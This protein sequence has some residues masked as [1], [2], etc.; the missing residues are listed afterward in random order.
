MIDL[1]VIDLA[2]LLLAPEL[3]ARLLLAEA[4]K[5]G[6]SLLCYA[7]L[8]RDNMKYALKRRGFLQSFDSLIYSEMLPELTS[9]ELRLLGDLSKTLWLRTP[10]EVDYSR[11]LHLRPKRRRLLPKALRMKAHVDSSPRLEQANPSDPLA[12]E[13]DEKD[14]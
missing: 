9:G 11:L 1:V 5:D 7:D 12:P 2:A 3:R 10:E 6:L 8:P 13:P 4:S 14:F